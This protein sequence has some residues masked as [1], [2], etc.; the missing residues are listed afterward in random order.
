MSEDIRSRLFAK[1]AQASG[2]RR[3]S[4]VG[5]GLYISRE[6][7]TRHGGSIWAESELGKGSTFSFRIPIA[8]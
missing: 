5:L 8:Q 1:F 3:S 6:I 4:G 7:I 2:K